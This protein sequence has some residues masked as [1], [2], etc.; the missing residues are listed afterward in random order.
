MNKES[1]SRDSCPLKLIFLFLRI[2]QWFLF[3]NLNLID[4]S[5][6]LT[7]LL[8]TVNKITFFSYLLHIFDIFPLSFNQ[9]C[10][11]KFI[12]FVSVP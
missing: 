12:V 3:P 11:S 1:K 5:I 9:F 2:H 8:I 10:G 7:N 4:I 6:L